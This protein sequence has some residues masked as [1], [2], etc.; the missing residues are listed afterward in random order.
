MQVWHASVPG[1]CV[2][3]YGACPGKI[4]GKRHKKKKKRYFLAEHINKNVFL[5]Q[6]KKSTFF[7][8]EMSLNENVLED[9]LYHMAS[10]G[11][12]KNVLIFVLS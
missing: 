4:I 12:K 3:T 11:K 10:S 1:V 6:R 7:L 9:T 2:Y 5:C 8:H